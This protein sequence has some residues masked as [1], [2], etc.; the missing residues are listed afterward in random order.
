MNAG[1]GTR[2]RISAR[3]V[4]FIASFPGRETYDAGA[5]TRRLAMNVTLNVASSPLLALPCVK[6]NHC[7]APTW[8]VLYM[9]LR[10]SNWI[11]TQQLNSHFFFG[12]LSPVRESFTLSTVTVC[13]I[14]IYDFVILVTLFT[15]GL[16]V[17]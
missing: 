6:W 1:Q 16:E 8:R 9:N 2:G 4:D 11:Q 12:N 7:H 5:A 17:C 13:W 14:Y 3:D 15:S 10:L